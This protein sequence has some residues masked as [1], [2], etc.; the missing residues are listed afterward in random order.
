MAKAHLVV[1]F[2]L[3]PFL[4]I[5]AWSPMKLH[6]F[7]HLSTTQLAVLQFHLAYHLTNYR[8][9]VHQRKLYKIIHLNAVEKL[10]YRGGYLFPSPQVEDKSSRLMFLVQVV[11][12]AHSLYAQ[13]LRISAAL[14][15]SR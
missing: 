12:P 9:S 6:S 13:T 11:T 15:R 7:N 8:V 4:R 14:L 2:K 3:L 5:I 1:S 10:I